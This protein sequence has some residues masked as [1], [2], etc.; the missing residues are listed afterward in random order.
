[1]VKNKAYDIK[2]AL[3]IKTN[4]FKKKIVFI[5]NGAIHSLEKFLTRPILLKLIDRYE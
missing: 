5:S 2:K 1:M 4:Q 3:F